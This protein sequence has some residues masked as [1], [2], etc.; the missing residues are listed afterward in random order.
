MQ[1]LR[2]YISLVVTCLLVA[3]P[4]MAWPEETGFTRQDRL[5]GTVTPE[6]AWWDLWHY[7]LHVQVFPDTQ[8]ISGK[9]RITF[10]VLQPATRMQ[11]DLQ[12]PMEITKI[13]WGDRSLAWERDGNVIWIDF[14]E[15]PAVATEQS[16]QIDYAG[17]PVV[18]Q[19]PP[20][21][22]GFTWDRDDRGQHFIATTC[23][24]IG[25]SLWW[26]LKDHLYDE[27]DRGMNI[28]L[29]VPEDLVAVA[30][31]RLAHTS[32]QISERTKTYDWVVQNPINNYCVNVNIGDYVS[33]GETYSGE[34]GPLDVQYWVLRHQLDQ[35]QVQFK[36]APRVL[37][38]FEYW[39]GKYPFY[40]DSYKLV[41]VPYTGME[42]QSSVTYGNYFRNGYRGRDLSGT[43]VGFKFDFIIVHES[44]HEWFGNNISMKDSADMWIHESFTNYSENLFVEYHF[45]QKEAQDY[46]I[47]C[48]RLIKNDQPIIPEYNVNQ[49]GSGDMYYK[50][51]NMLHTMR[52]IVND[53][54]KWRAILRGLNAT[55]WH[56]TV[57]TRQVETYINE[58]SGIDFTKFFDQYLR[59]TKIP[60]LRYQMDDHA[61]T[62]HWEN[63]VE[64]FAYPVLVRVN[65][66]PQ[67][68]TPTAQ[69]QTTTFAQAIQSFELDRNYYMECKA[70]E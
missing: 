6:R 58:Q 23:F 20:W 25:A 48:R 67:T 2:D 1:L 63:V 22:G 65:G 49:L 35:A 42:H 31:G 70:A 51:G 54:E 66:Q 40:E 3:T 24:G 18:S 64:G 52:H 21:S 32:H 15:S 13:T 30:N 36:E 26:P 44:G 33:F 17:K 37:A 11:I 41:A 50:G 47:G 38:A 5:R 14:P 16:I 56:Q 28:H 62:Y 8:S 19:R 34:G 9:N 10:G 46:V 57:T 7:D 29:T 69:P 39:F 27:P 60:L 12:P 53:D 55:F 45:T 61:V 4:T 43:G 59:T 68:L